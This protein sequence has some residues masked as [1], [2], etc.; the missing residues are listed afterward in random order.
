[1]A[2]KHLGELLV[3][4]GLIDGPQLAAALDHQER[5]GGRIEQIVVDLG[6]IPE[7]RMLVGLAMKLG[8][9]MVERPP[10]V[11]D[12]RVLAEISADFAARW[13][14]F[15]IELQREA[16]GET[17]VI[18]SSDPTNDEA[19]DALRFQTGRVVRVTLAGASKLQGWIRYF[20]FGGQASAKVDD[21]RAKTPTQVPVRA[22]AF[23]DEMP[24]VTGQHL[25][26]APAPAQGP[27]LGAPAIG[28]VLSTPLSLPKPTGPAPTAA[29][30]ACR[31]RPGRRHA[32]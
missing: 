19:L 2:R 5:V 25:E 24:L 22:S 30:D 3:E 4:A 26:E 7:R 23:T 17:L 11:M 29:I 14:V 32:R 15:P 12:P 31:V 9:A 8:V 28:H 20:Y 21:A 1:M 13:L 16:H 27:E 10:E 6:F 18:A